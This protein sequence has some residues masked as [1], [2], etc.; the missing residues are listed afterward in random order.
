MRSILGEVDE[1]FVC[2]T[3][4]QNRT[5][6]KSAFAKSN[7]ENNF[8]M[9]VKENNFQIIKCL[10]SHWVEPFPVLKRFF[11]PVGGL[12]VLAKN[13]FRSTRMLELPNLN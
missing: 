4:H 3:N 11:Q 1:A 9:L 8:G 10:P 13:M 6:S 5:P 7:D 2:V 12:F